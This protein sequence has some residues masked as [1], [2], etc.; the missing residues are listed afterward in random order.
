[1]IAN[2]SELK[3][4]MKTWNLTGVVGFGVLIS[5]LGFG[6]NED[7]AHH[8]QVYAAV[9]AAEK[10]MKVVEG[11]YDDDGL[12]FALKGWTQD[13]VLKKIVSQV[14]GEDGDGSEEFYLEEGLPLFV[15][16]HYA[17]TVAD[18]E[19]PKQMESR[20]YFKGG[21]L[22][23]CIGPG[24]VEI[25]PKDEN[26]KADEERLTGLCAAF[27]TALS[28]AKETVVEGRFL[29]IDEGDYF[30]WTMTDAKGE[31]V[32]YFILKSDA[33]IDK[34]VEAPEKYVGKRCRVTC[35]KGMETIPEAGGK[36]EVEQVLKV[37]WLGK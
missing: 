34:V 3:I 16:S 4:D 32:S 36:M 17:S 2:A 31:E 6:A 15:F 1:M 11:T 9:N 29:R 12:A 21:K 13:G 27:V 28:G 30:H 18:G 26:A 19:K 10:K 35:K 24:G 20:Y 7:T 23:K 5:G 22:I 25:S 37:E 8:R 14:P 33:S